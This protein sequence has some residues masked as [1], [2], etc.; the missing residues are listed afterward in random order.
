MEE[1]NAVL[2]PI[3]SARGLPKSCYTDPAT[4]EKETKRI[5]AANWAAI[6]FGI[7]VPKPGCVNPVSFLVIPLVVVCGRSGK[8]K[9]FENVCRHRGMILIEEAE[10]LSGPITFRYHAWAYDLDG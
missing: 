6:G 4:F 2:Q 9:V 10:R 5:F 1:F 8:I 7:D 3:E